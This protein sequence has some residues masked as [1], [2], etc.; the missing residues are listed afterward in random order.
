M[1][2]ETHEPEEQVHDGEPEDVRS[3]APEDFV[4][5]KLEVTVMPDSVSMHYDIR[6]KAEKGHISSLSASFVLT[7]NGVVEESFA[8]NSQQATEKTAAGQGFL[9]NLGVD[10]GVFADRG[11]GQL[12]GLVAGV[13]HDAEGNPHNYI[14]MQQFHLDD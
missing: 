11:K 8:G 1:S 10:T 3:D 2:D 9:G 5:G 4:D 12:F 13:C 14:F 7:V 6:P